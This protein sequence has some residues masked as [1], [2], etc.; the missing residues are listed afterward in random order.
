MEWWS[1]GVLEYWSPIPRHSS[2]PVLRFFR[3]CDMSDFDGDV[4]ACGQVELLELVH[5]FGCG[6]DDVNEALV[7]P[8]LEGLLRFF[9]T[10]G[11]AQNRKA[12][13][14]GRERDGA[15]DSGTGAFNGI[16]DVAGRLVYDAMIKGLESNTNT[17]S[18]HRKNNCL[19]MVFNC[20]P[21]SGKRSAEYKHKNL[22]AQ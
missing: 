1:I 18:S 8:L 3:S 4:H 10:M 13:D 19:L 21:G 9:I 17:L 2:T 14:A 22:A 15:C 5:G 6:L 20:R 16:G 12:L 7:S 11:G